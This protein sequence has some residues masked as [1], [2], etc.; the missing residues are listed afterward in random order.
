M[1]ARANSLSGSSLLRNLRL[2]TTDGITAAPICYLILPGNFIV[3]ALLV[4]CFKLS[5]AVYGVIGSMPYWGNFAQGLVLPLL[6]RRLSPKV[7]AI[8]PAVAQVVCWAGLT[9]ALG[10]LPED[11]PE[12]SGGWFLGFFAVSAVVSAL[13]S[14]GWIAWIQEWVPARLR[15]GYFGLRNRLLQVAQIAFLLVVAWLL[16][17]AGGTVRVFQ[18]IFGGAV[19]LR[20]FS[21][22]AQASTQAGA[23]VAAGAGAGALPWREQL[24]AIGRTGAFKWFIAYGAV[25][26]FAANFFGPFYPVFMMEQLGRSAGNV[27]FFIALTSV[28]G[29]LS[30]Q[31]W[32]ALGNRFGNKPVM[33]FAMI[34]W[35]VSNFSWAFLTPRNSWLLYGMYVFGGIMNA[36]FTLSLFNIQLK[37]IPPAAKALAISLNLAVTALA[38]AVAP[39]LG[40]RILQTM[41]ANA[42]A[43]AGEAGAMSPLAVYH[44]LVL[45][46]PVLGLLAC[47]LLVRVREVNAHPLASVVGAMRNIRTLSAMLGLGFFVNH[48]FY[49]QPKK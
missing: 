27:S 31:A 13:A 32:G 35:Q 43:G 49:R 16:W 6:N 45:V 10:F 21:I 23:G 26:G 47:L 46:Q 15:H 3:A 48:I 29:A 42:A 41:L 8:W 25:W 38:T 39:I 7:A 34:A 19:F 40:G 37:L 30:Y 12:T 36:G 24:A 33:L 5:P 28:G 17:S 14:V 11:R 9:V 22:W 44:T 18:V 4:G 20:V 2:S 1:S